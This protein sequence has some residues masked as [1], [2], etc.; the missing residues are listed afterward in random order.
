MK[1]DKEKLR[2]W[3]ES[4]GIIFIFCE[5]F[6]KLDRTFDKSF[7]NQLQ[8]APFSPD[9]AVVWSRKIILATK[10]ASWPAI[11]HEAGHILCS[12]VPPDKC[13]D[14]FCFFGWERAVVKHLKLSMSE[15]LK[16]NADYCIDFRDEDKTFETIKD[17]QDI[18][19][20]KKRF[21][22]EILQIAY[23]H[24]FVTMDGKPLIAA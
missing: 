23:E 9:V 11:L 2:S 24:N 4:C 6:S 5:C 21:Y 10:K 3:L 20:S 14:E 18:Q 13:D 16:D 8:F 12:N 19:T 17:I 7:L 22:S 1:S 15:W